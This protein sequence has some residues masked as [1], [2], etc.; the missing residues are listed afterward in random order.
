MFLTTQFLQSCRGCASSHVRLY[1][2]PWA[3]AS[4]ASAWAGGFFAT[5]EA[6]LL[7]YLTINQQS[8]F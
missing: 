6:Q 2:T 8:D 5:W 4:Q 1:A 7:Q 3:V